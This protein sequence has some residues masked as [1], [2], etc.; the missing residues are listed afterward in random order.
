MGMCTAYNFNNILRFFKVNL[1]IIIISY[2]N[3]HARRKNLAAV[4][5]KLNAEKH[6]SENA[7]DNK[8]GV[9]E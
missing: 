3:G 6:K 1:F 7:N 5:G 8:K 4:N 9:V 2:L